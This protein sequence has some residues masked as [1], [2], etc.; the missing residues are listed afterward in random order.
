MVAEVG[1]AGIPISDQ[2]WH[3][4]GNVHVLARQEKSG[5]DQHVNHGKDGHWYTDKANLEEANGQVRVCT[6]S[7]ALDNE[8]GAG[9]NDRTSAFKWSG[10]RERKR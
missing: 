3:R 9:A 7:Q 10:K 5:A 2:S 6:C 4:L 1:A 8:V